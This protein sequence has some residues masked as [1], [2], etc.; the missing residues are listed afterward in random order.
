MSSL[1][2]N[3]RLEVPASESSSGDKLEG[4]KQIE[5]RGPEVFRV[6]DW[7]KLDSAP[8]S[9]DV[10]RM[11]GLGGR[12]GAARLAILVN[13]P[14]MLRAANMFAEQAGLQG[15]QVRVFVDATEAVTWLYRD[16]PQDVLAQQWPL[17]ESTT[18]K[19]R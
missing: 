19:V 16:V 17:S 10:A 13:T 12:T 14:R 5:R 8:T 2:R 7:T 3:W 4:S 18:G 15:A 6:L 11:A 9:V 1:L